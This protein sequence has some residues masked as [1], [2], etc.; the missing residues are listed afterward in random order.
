MALNAALAVGLALIAWQGRARWNEAQAQRRASLNLP[1][2]RITPP[3]MTAVQKPEPVQAAKYVD[4]AAKN[5]FSKDR[6]PAVIVDAPKVEAPKI[7]PS[8]PIV[9]GALGLPSGISAIMAERS[10]AASRSVRVGDSIGDF[11]VVALDMR[12]VTFEWN[13]TLLARNL[14][15]LADRSGGAAAGVAQVVASGPAVAAPPPPSAA[16]T[17]AVLGKEIGTPDAPARACTPGDNSPAGTVVDGYRKTGAASPF[18]LMG[19]SWVPSK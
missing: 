4:V 15:D 10:G 12:K 18:G 17:S 16:P 8:L 19:C 1:V 7:M 3:P 11:K 6:N 13:G 2:K 5:L 9:Y 14:D